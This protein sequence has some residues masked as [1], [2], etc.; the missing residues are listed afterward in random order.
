M[1]KTVEDFHATAQ[2]AQSA[3]P[4]A[5]GLSARAGVFAVKTGV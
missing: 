2:I 3:Y 1:C 4:V 5:T